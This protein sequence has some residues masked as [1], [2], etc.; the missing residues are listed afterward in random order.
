MLQDT[1]GTDMLWIDS[2]FIGPSGIDLAPSNLPNMNAEFRGCRVESN[3][4]SGLAYAIRANSEL[5]VLDRCNLDQTGGLSTQSLAV[6]PDAGVHG[7][8]I[9]VEV[10]W[11]RMTGRITFV[12]AGIVGDSRL[13]VGAS[14]YTAISVA[15]TL[16]EQSATVEG[17]SIFY[18]NSSS[19]IAPEDVQDALDHIMDVIGL[20][21]LGGYSLTLDTAYDGINSTTASVGSGDGRRILADQGPVIIQAADPPFVEPEVGQL[22]GGLQTEGNVQVGTPGSPEMDLD[23]NPFGAGPRILGG[24]LI[25]P[26]TDT[27]F[28]RAIPVFSVMAENTGASRY[29][30]YNLGL[31]T[32]SADEASR[33]E[34]GRVLIKGGDSLAGGGT[35]PDAGSVYVQCGDGHDAT[36]DPGEIW[37]SPGYNQTLASSGRVHFTNPTAATQSDLV[38][39]GAFVGG[40][41]GD[42]SFYVSGVGIVTASIL[43]VDPLATAQT[44]LNAL[45]GITC[46]INPGNDPIQ[47]LTEA[48]GPNA[49]VYFTQDDQGGALNTALGDFTYSGGAVFTPGTFPEEISMGATGADELTIYGDLIVTGSLSGGGSGAVFVNRKTINVGDSP[50]A[51]LNTD[52]YLGVDV[53]GGPVIINL[54]TTLPGTGDGRELY[55]KD[56]SA[57]AAANNITIQVAGGALIDNAASLVLSADWSGAVIVGNGLT[58][59]ST[60]WYIV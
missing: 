44:K 51:V 29:H 37:F 43:N 5:L 55:I 22:N 4:V 32:K 56:E 57:N 39:A 24:N 6:H 40:V 26:D 36:G 1:T 13:R 46:A 53:S 38:A 49:E 58:G 15:G 52:H 45:P 59:A 48:K 20:T 30:S 23:P 9:V 47:V 16:T 34:I 25:F 2:E 33:S 8:D 12:T 3:F 60:R 50:Y 41:A 28:H 35:P 18:D 54:P 14:D 11:T 31:E 42:I 19:G 17:T 10:R 27:A 21:G 7:S